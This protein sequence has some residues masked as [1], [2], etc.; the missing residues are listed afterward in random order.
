MSSSRSGR[1]E[2]RRRLTRVVRVGGVIPC[3]TEALQA[4]TVGMQARFVCPSDIAY[5]DSGSLPTIEPG[6][7]IAFEVELIDIIKR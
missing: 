6:A 3:W 5:G 1:F 2:Y 7:A 4:M